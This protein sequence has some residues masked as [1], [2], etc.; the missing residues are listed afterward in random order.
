MY[1]KIVCLVMVLCLIP[2]A[3]AAENDGGIEEKDKFS[4]P[5][6]GEGLAW[7]KVQEAE[8]EGVKLSVY[9]A[10][11][12]NSK[13][14]I[15]LIVEHQQVNTDGQKLAR[16]KGT[17]NGLVHGL[18]QGGWTGLKGAQPD[19]KTPVAK[20]VEFAISGKDE[21]GKA[22]FAR[23][24]VVFGKNVYQFQVISASEEDAA[25]MA[26]VADWLKEQ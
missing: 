18:Q 20:K 23:G 8:Q 26:K 13:S 3:R 2:G 14:K 12:E 15:V 5:S 1:L 22:G 17:Y 7:K 10:V 16:V 4:L 25:A 9:A 11:K 24:A 21:Q 19:L 6:P